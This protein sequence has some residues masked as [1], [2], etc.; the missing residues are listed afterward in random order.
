MIGRVRE[1]AWA[2]QD[3]LIEA[4]EEYAVDLLYLAFGFVFLYYGILKPLPVETPVR[5]NV[6]IFL[7]QFGIPVGIGIN[8]IGWYEMV[9]GVLFLFRRIRLVFW[10]FLVHQAV[11][12]LVLVTVP[13]T[14]FNPPWLVIGPLKL[15]WVLDSFAA[16]IGKNLVFTAAFLLLAT[17]ELREQG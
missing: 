10:P 15:P 9:L 6:G 5:E 12:L 14:V 2:A 7:G 3:R 17:L 8:V 11:T 16:F 4:Y 13:Y 1:R